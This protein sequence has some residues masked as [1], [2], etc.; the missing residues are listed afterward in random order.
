MRW[1]VGARHDRGA[2]AVLAPKSCHDNGGKALSSVFGIYAVF[3]TARL[4]EQ[5]PHA[6]CMEQDCTSKTF[7]QIAWGNCLRAKPSCKLHGAIVYEQSLHANCMRVLHEEGG[8]APVIG[9]RCLSGRHDGHSGRSRHVAGGGGKHFELEEMEGDHIMPWREG[10][11]T[12]E[13][14]C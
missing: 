10:G 14:N 12:T 1:R 2:G 11:R 6:N 9:R 5:N 4:H 3:V 8:V 13:E 7:M